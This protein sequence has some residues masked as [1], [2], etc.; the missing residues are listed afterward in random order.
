[1]AKTQS[2]EK[3]TP[4]SV[5]ASLFEPGA[6]DLLAEMLDNMPDPDEVLREL[7]L[8]RANLRPMLGD[9]EI[10]AALETRFAAV[11]GTPWRLEPAEGPAFDFVWSQLEPRMES[12]VRAAWRAV[13]FGYSVQEVTYEKE[14]GRTV[15]GSVDDRPFDWFSV[16]PDGKLIYHPKSSSTMKEGEECD[17]DY[18]FFLTRRYPSYRQPYGEALLTRLYWPWFFRTQ[19]SKFWARFLERFGAPLLLGK[20]SGDT[21]LMA[22]SLAKALQSAV[23]A[24]G[25]NDDVQAI[26]PT[27]NGEAFARFD[28]RF[29]KSIQKVILGQ[30]LTS[31]VGTVGSFAAAKVHDEVRDDR[32]KADL[33]LVQATIQRMVDAL[34]ALNFPSIKLTFVMAD[35]TGLEIERAERDSK[36]VAAGVLKLTEK[37]LLDRYDFEP[38]DFTIPEGSTG[39]PVDPKKPAKPAGAKAAMFAAGIAHFAA[40]PSKFTGQQQAVE[41]LADDAL[42]QGGGSPIDPALVRKAIFAAKDADDLAERLAVI[43]AEHDPKTFNAILER[44]LFAA[45]VVGYVHAEGKE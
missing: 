18:K 14:G 8:T 29:S 31:D 6:V 10:E 44:A 3:N 15:W 24:I 39:I 26:S 20:T 36:L 16:Q 21:A 34:L 1:M 30:T 13:I 38:G 43:L 28:S 32:R 11:V 35:D 12:I 5:P 23:A 25:E 37:Y 4:T 27:G 2:K 7:G 45:D 41:D 33:R 42:A 40:N 19:S 22:S 9:D 17:Q